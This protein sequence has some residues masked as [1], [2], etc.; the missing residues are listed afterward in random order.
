LWR[1]FLK[2]FLS[3]YKKDTIFASSY[4]KQWKN[5]ANGG[6]SLVSISLP[7][8]YSSFRK[9]LLS[10]RLVSDFELQKTQLA[11]ISGWQF[12]SAEGTKMT[13]AFLSGI[14]C[15]KP[16]F[17]NLGQRYCQYLSSKS[18]K[19][20]QTSSK[21][22]SAL[23]SRK[24]VYSF[25]AANDNIGIHA[26]NSSNCSDNKDFNN[27]GSENNNNSNNNVNDGNSN[28]GVNNDNKENDEKNVG[29]G[30]IYRL[31]SN[32]NGGNNVIIC[33]DGINNSVSIL[34]DNGNIVGNVNNG[35]IFDN[36]SIGSV[37]GI[38]S[39]G[40]NNSISIL[41]NNRN[42]VGNGNDYGLFSN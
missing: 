35:G 36:G 38:F 21:V 31:F 39:D 26:K 2:F 6:S 15:T 16:T 5:T 4:L 28:N 20:R 14:F 42:V 10:N 1:F 3:Y 25:A 9:N 23:E 18:D 17:E 32:G 29:N 12:Q 41:C 33:S 11:A 13:V 19:C 40:V 37:G 27:V 30:S 22:R 24:Y 8:V 7:I 34:C